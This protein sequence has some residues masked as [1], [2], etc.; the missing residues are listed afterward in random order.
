[1]KL[2]LH[3]CCAPCTIYPL[4][5]LRDQGFQ[6]TGYFYN[7]NIHPFREFEKRKNTL[8]EYAGISNLEIFFDDQYDLEL[9]LNQTRPWGS[10]RCRTCYE[11]RLEA[12][13]RQAK[14]Q[15]FDAFSTTLLYSR[16][17]KHDWIKAVGAKTGERFEIPFHYQDFRP[18]WDKG[19]QIAKELGLYRQPYCGCIFSEKERFAA[20]SG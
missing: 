15:G 13:A 9:F 16:Y 17:Q 12:T 4:Q 19:I 14:S 3:I 7:P 2:L 5:T 20:K 6:I 11:I 8:K 18:G 1:M 10:E